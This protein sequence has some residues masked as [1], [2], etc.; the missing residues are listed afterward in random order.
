MVERIRAKIRELNASY[1]Q[2]WAE[3]CGIESP[4]LDK[5]GVDAACGFVAQLA[6]RRGWQVE[7][8][9]QPMAGDAVCI[10]MNPDAPAAPLA[11]SGHVDTVHP[12]GAFGVPAVR[13]DEENI[14]GPGTM[15][16]KGGVVAGLL[17]MDALM[18]CGFVQRPVRLLLQTDEEVGSRLSG[19]A[20]IRW[21]CEKAKDAVAFINLEPST[22][23]KTCLK[24]KGIVSHR[25]VVKG[26]EAHSSACATDGASAIADAA[27]RILALEQ[28]KD[29]EGIT[30][31]CGVVH[32]GTAVNTVPGECTFDANFRFV[33]Q[34]QFAWIDCYVKEL[35]AREF[36]PGCTC[37][38]T[39]LSMRVA[40][41]LVQ[42]NLELLEK[43]NAAFA[44][45][46]L[47]Q[48]VWS[49]QGGGSD[50]ADV[51]A[52]GIPCL[53]SLGVRGGGAHSIRESGRLDSLAEAAERVAVLACEL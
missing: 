47:P 14:Y 8:C 39:Q 9:R 4:T 51:T 17:A 41:E 28:L 15:D 44:R 26:I 3:L 35:A 22:A 36:V 10:T 49:W 1:Y 32:G 25:F 46:G 40:M 45:H 2:I 24:R 23:G 27:H 12:V 21:I 34:E 48:L 33:T 16:C 30:C 7:Y 52:F 42:R 38:V 53:D 19:K 5:A 50:A 31:N 37:T 6:Y 18:Q 29:A 11:I 20:T 13:M 43:A